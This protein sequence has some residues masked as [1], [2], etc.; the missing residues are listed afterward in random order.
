MEMA[1]KDTREDVFAATPPLE[2]KKIL[3][4]LYT[5]RER[6]CLD[7]ID[8]STAYFHAKARREIYVELPKEDWEEGVCGMLEKSMYGARDAARHWEMEYTEMMVE[9]GFTPGVHCPYAFWHK[10]RDV[11]V[12][13]HGDDFTVLGKKESLDWFRKVISSSMDVKFRERLE[14]GKEGA[15]R[16]LNRIVTSIKDGIE[17]GADQRRA[18]TIVKEAGL[19]ENSK[20][21][22]TPGVNE[23]E[24]EHEEG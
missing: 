4:S 15:V 20:E 13:V 21:V 8:V 17:Y 7:F 3:F 10:E 5:S 6:L 11:R 19:E 12:V 22:V 24:D 18:E 14:S 1:L 16:I 2:A 9:A 23:K